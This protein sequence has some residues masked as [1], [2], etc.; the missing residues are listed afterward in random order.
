MLCSC[1][2][3]L[4]TFCLAPKERGPNSLCG[5]PSSK[6]SVT[7]LGAPSQGVRVRPTSVCRG[8]LS[9]LGSR[10]CIGGADAPPYIGTVRPLSMHDCY[11]CL[12]PCCERSPCKCKHLYVHRACLDRMAR[13]GFRR[14]PVC[15]T[16]LP[17]LRLLLK[18]MFC[19][20]LLKCMTRE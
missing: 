12:E 9:C 1:Y 19:L 16:P 4:G 8:P 10:A 7:R 18:W 17:T 6:R 14:C 15:L 3:V 2:R 13:K 5:V 11:I 20:W